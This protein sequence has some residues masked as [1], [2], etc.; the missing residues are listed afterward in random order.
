MAGA[1]DVGQL[2]E[3]YGLKLL[4]PPTGAYCAFTRPVHPIGIQVID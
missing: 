1:K 2:V 3:Q 4:T